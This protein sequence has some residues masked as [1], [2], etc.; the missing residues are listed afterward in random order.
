M[1]NM[2]QFHKNTQRCYDRRVLLCWYMVPA[3]ERK[4]SE[5]FPCAILTE[6]RLQPLPPYLV[7]L[8]AD[9]FCVFSWLD[10]AIFRSIH[11]DL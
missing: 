3:F 4:N 1:G 11:Y 6:E 8:M 5:R 10:S 7:Y 2:A 9:G